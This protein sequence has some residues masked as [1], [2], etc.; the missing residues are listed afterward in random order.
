[1]RWTRVSEPSRRKNKHVKAARDTIRKPTSG[2]YPLVDQ[3]F[4]GAIMGV[5]DLE[6]RIPLPSPPSQVR[7]FPCLIADA[8]TASKAATTKADAAKV[9]RA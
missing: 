5:P 1:M 6:S 4:T 8:E 2:K 3:R 9:T 7:G